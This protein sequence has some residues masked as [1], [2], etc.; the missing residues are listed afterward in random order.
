MV[1]RGPRVED[2]VTSRRRPNHKRFQRL[3]E[4]V[5]FTLGLLEE[6]TGLTAVV[7]I[8]FVAASATPA[9]SLAPKTTRSQ[10]RG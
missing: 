4:M 8:F 3:H 5:S 6:V 7:A 1:L 10:R 9:R 2:G